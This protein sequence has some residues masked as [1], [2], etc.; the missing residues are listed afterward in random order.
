MSAHERLPLGKCCRASG[1]VSL[2]VDEVAFLRK[3]VVQAGV[4][5]GEFLQRLHPSEPLH[6]A[7]S[8]AERQVAIFGPVVQPTAHFATLKIAQFPHRRWVGSQPVGDHGFGPTMPLQRLLQKV[9]SRR[10]IPFLGDVALQD[11]ALVIDGAPE[12][13]QLAVIFT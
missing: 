11:F 4:D 8:S 6:R 1:A 12:V 10:F 3:M 2:A 13:M 5:G 7:F 9:Q